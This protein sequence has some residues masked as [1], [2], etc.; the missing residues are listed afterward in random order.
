MSHFI[1]AIYRIMIE[2]D[3]LEHGME[4]LRNDREEIEVIVLFSYLTVC[5]VS[6]STN[7]RESIASHMIF[8]VPKNQLLQ[9]RLVTVR[10]N[11]GLVESHS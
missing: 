2:F 9:Y 5:D 3:P 7:F 6:C 11:I 8:D 4:P 10:T 1:V